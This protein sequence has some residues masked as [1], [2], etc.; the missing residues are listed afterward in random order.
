MRMLL[1]VLFFLAPPFW[2]TK[3]PERWTDREIDALRHDSPWAQAVGPDPKVLVYLATAGPIEDAEEEA[4]LRTKNPL[5]EPDPDY[6]D[7]LREN[8]EKEFVLAIP[9]VTL[10]GL[11]KP[12][13]EKLME[14]QTQMVIGRRTYKIVGHFPP[15]EADPVLRLVFPREA[16]ATDKS[17]I[18]HLYLPG[19]PFPERETEF[20]VK[21]LLYH[22][23]LAM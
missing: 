9:E 12:G 3:P 1:A 6:L 18:F 23:K 15:T 10:K 17:V 21:D 8:G 14:D 19:I 4:R 7:Y 13:E 16:Q 20:R 22:G 2:E 11:A 5:Q